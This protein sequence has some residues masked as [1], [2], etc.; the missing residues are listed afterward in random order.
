[1]KEIVILT[2]TGSFDLAESIARSLVEEKLAACVNVLPEIR[3]LYRWEG[4]L[5][6]DKEF[7]LL[8]KSTEEKF[9][10]V[11]SSIRRLHTYDVPEVIALAITA[12]DST[13]LRWLRQ[14]VE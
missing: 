8:I 13:Y 5:C 12:G 2:T 4:K 11:R 9:E 14:Q 10:A 3:S 6:E 7:L 1:M